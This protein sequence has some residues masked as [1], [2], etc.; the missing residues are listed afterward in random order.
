M[1]FYNIKTMVLASL[2]SSMLAGAICVLTSPITAE[3][4]A[5]IASSVDRTAKSD[6]L[7]IA[8]RVRRDLSSTKKPAS[9]KP[10]LVGCESAF[11]P[12]ADP[13]R[14]NILNHCV[15]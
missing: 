10:T 12:F 5:V 2:L 8:R 6:R 14:P 1:R 15:T 3:S 13:G 4:A 9:S 7:D 11:S